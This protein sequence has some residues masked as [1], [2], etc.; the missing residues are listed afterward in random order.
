MYVHIKAQPACRNHRFTN[1]KNCVLV[2][3]R[4]L[5]IV[6]T[7]FKFHSEIPNTLGIMLPEVHSF[8]YKSPNFLSY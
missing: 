4:K 5:Y 2:N 6:H 7:H 8:M 3:F 1:L